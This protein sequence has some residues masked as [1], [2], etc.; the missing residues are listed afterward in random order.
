M[1]MLCSVEGI[2]IPRWSRFAWWFAGFVVLVAASNLLGQVAGPPEAVAIALI[3]LAATGAMVPLVW[4]GRRDLAA[5]SALPPS[6]I[7]P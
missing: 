4:I 3:W 2:A 7:A 6:R 5:P 1:Y